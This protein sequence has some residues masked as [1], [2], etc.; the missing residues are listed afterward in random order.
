[1][2]EVL[3]LDRLEASFLLLTRGPRPLSLDGRGVGCGLPA[4]PIPLDELR[5]LLAAPATPQRARDATLRVLVRRARTLRG[6]ALIGL[7]GVL[8]P[9][10]RGAVMPLVR[11]YPDHAADLEAEILTGLLAAVDTVCLASRDVA[12]RLNC[13]A[14]QAGYR[15]LAWLQ[16]THTLEG[17]AGEALVGARTWQ[18]PWSGA[19]LEG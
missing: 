11:A 15:L 4:R 18:L 17:A 16:V 7:V 2:S 3:L 1:M 6:A 12:D 19:P 14:A 8:L 5:R 10:L 13:L 9:D